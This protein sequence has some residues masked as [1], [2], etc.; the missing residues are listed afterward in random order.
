MTLELFFE[1]KN[2]SAPPYNKDG[3]HRANIPIKPCGKPQEL[4][5]TRVPEV[6]KRHI[7]RSG[8]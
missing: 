5:S 1:K 2:P 6:M 7:K 3:A 4:P 8:K